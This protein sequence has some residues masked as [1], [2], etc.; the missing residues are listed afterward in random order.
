MEDGDGAAKFTKP[1]WI[2][3]TYSAILKNRRYG[4]R[5]KTMWAAVGIAVLLICCVVYF[6]PMS[7][8]DCIGADDRIVLSISTLSVPNGE[9][10]IDTADYSD[11]TTEQQKSKRLCWKIAHIHVL[12]AHCC[13]RHRCPI[14]AEKQRRSTSIMMIHCCI[15]SKSQKTDSFCWTTESTK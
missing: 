14:S 12:C 10:G 3:L 7:L 1:C 5:K 13:R 11:I 4:M 6:R 8:S 2:S 15:L 9:A